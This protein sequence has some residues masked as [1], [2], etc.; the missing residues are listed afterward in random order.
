M[1]TP[2]MFLGNALHRFLCSP[3]RF[4][5]STSAHP[6]KMVLHVTLAFFFHKPETGA[7]CGSFHN[8]YIVSPFLLVL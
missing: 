8:I 4:L 3:L 6:S 2:R 5:M 7:N 1:N